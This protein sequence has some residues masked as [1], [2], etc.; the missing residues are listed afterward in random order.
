[1]GKAILGLGQELKADDGVGRYVINGLKRNKSKHTLIYSD[2]PE[3][4]FTK[5]RKTK[6]S[7]LTIVDAADFS[8]KPGEIK[9]TSAMKEKS[10]LSTHSTSITKLLRYINQSIGITDITL[11]LIQAKSLEF[12]KEMSDEVKAAGDTVVKLLL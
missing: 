1:M 7:S 9:I 2:V 3:N 4:A 6:I 8:G 11:V 5:L 12:G 10:Q